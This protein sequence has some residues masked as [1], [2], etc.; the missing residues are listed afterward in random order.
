[1]IEASSEISTRHNSWRLVKTRFG[2]ICPKQSGRDS[3]SKDN[4]IAKL[5]RKSLSLDR[6]N[7]KKNKT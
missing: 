2:T 1:M 5:S 4:I 3:L 7:K 6:P